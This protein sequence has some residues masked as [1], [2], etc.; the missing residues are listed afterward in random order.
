[1]KYAIRFRYIPPYDYMTPLI[2]IPIEQTILEAE[3]PESAWT[4][5]IGHLPVNQQDW[6]KREE[7]FQCT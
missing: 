2:H 4:S 5:F 3:T 7:I 6:L 1:M